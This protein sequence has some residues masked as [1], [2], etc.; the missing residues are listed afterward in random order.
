MGYTSKQLDEEITLADQQLILALEA[1]KQEYEI[2]KIAAAVA[3]AFGGKKSS[4]EVKQDGRDISKRR[5]K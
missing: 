1:A 5:S 4:G 3:M 2:N